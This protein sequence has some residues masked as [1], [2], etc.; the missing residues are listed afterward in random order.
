MWRESRVRIGGAIRRIGCWLAG[1]YWRCTHC[2]NLEYR[3]REVT[4]WTC[5]LGEM[6][7]QG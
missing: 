7:Y 3:E 5:G 1:D 6:I 4:C 2:G